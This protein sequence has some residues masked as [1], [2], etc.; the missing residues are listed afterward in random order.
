MAQGTSSK[1]SPPAQEASPPATHAVW[2]SL[3]ADCL[4]RVAKMVLNSR[5]FR[6]LFWYTSGE[7]VVVAGG[8]I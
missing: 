6:K 2:P 5:A 8:A 3:Q 1:P 4:V 7:T